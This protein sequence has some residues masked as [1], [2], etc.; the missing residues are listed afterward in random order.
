MR[1]P[2]LETARLVLRPFTLADAPIVQRLA[3]AV[4]VADTTQN[5]PHPYPDGAAELWIASHAD[6]FAAGTVITFAIVLRATAELLGAIGISLSP[7]HHLG[8]LGYW[9]GA[10]YWNKGYTTEAA[11][12]VIDYGFETL[13]LH[14]IQARHFT[15]NPASGR[16][17]QKVGMTF[18]GIQ[19]ES[20]LKNG[21]YEDV[22]FY[23]ILA[24][25]QRLSRFG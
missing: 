16:V 18:E 12:A 23:S 15:R 9:I 14:R 10:P 5:I 4:E 24:S 8:E 7:R 2:S 11:A 3:G 13:G 25:E 20:V 1:Q 17:M 19:R 21:R 22:A 6:R